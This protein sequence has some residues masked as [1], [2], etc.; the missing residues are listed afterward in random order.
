MRGE[1]DDNIGHLLWGADSAKRDRWQD[2]LLE[3][4]CDPA[5]LD[6]PQGN[7]VYGHAEFSEFSSRTSR[8]TLQSKLARS[9]GD[10]RRK[11]FSPSSAHVDDSA[12]LCSSLY[13]PAGKFRHHQYRRPGIHGENSVNGC[14]VETPR[15]IGPQFHKLIEQVS[16]RRE[17]R[18]RF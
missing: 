8:V 13:V 15:T 5:R 11:A 18:I 1:K 14:C 12:E 17:E 16:F 10:F 2:C 3:F 7:R 4:P 6:G 9:I